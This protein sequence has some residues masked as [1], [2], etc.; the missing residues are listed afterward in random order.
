MKRRFFL[1][2]FLVLL[3]TVSIVTAL[4]LYFLKVERLRLIDQQIETSAS[5]V[6][7]SDLT[8]MP[9]D[10]IEELE[11]FFH[12]LLESRK[13][14]KII[15]IRD[16]NGK[17]LYSSKNADW[18][19]DDF[20]Q[21]VRWQTVTEE[22]HT[23]RILSIE[24]PALKKL[25]QIGM[26]LD[27]EIGL[28]RRL[29][30]KYVL[31]S[32]F[33][34]LLILGV[35]VLLTSMLLTPLRR[36]SLY[37]NHLSTEVESGT[38][39]SE[40]KSFSLLSRSNENDEF[41][42]LTRAV[43]KLRDKISIH[44]GIFQQ[45]TAQMAHSLKTPL[46]II[47]ANLEKIKTRHEPLQSDLA[48]GLKESLE[49]VQR[50]DST[51]SSF[52][53]WATIEGGSDHEGQIQAIN[54]QDR[55]Q[56][57]VTRLD[58][59]FDGR[60]ETRLQGSLRVFANLEHFD[61]ALSNLIV[62]ALKYSPTASKVVITSTSNQIVIE[63]KGPGIPEKVLSRI[64]EPFNFGEQTASHGTGLGLSWASSICK[65][66]GWKLSISSVPQG[67]RVALSGFDR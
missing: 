6:V 8:N 59:V 10:D 23:I 31:F 55:I 35:S 16:L 53:S 61:Q 7:S 20:K 1:T 4:H 67:T 50:L 48:N 39:E 5:L 25:L 64:G 36:L 27:S 43:L 29:D 42:D 30:A 47:R 2:I 57:M 54:A 38:M 14:N 41:A 45:W 44:Y 17:V 12:E 32:L 63:D 56:D 22:G 58:K 18:L 40:T 13:I 11:D 21:D 37:L 24:I 51:I 3:L 52:L 15:L 34:A 33:T 19:P 65:K 9:L 62:N 60:L 49:E 66:Y 46:T 28:W 26:V